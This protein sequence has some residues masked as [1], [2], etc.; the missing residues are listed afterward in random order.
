MYKEFHG[1]LG[2]FRK[3]KSISKETFDNSFQIEKYSVAEKR[4]LK[5][6]VGPTLT[7]KEHQC[8]IAQSLKQNPTH[9]Y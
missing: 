3:G 8:R 2:G 1:L 4:K 6:R 5:I 7:L 9:D